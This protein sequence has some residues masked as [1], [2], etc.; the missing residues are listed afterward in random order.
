MQVGRLVAR[1]LTNPQIGTELGISLDG[2]KYHVSE[3]LGRLSLSTRREIAEQMEHI[4]EE[5]VMKARMV[6]ILL[7]VEDVSRSM[8]FYRDRL[9]FNVLHE[10][11]H[12]NRVT[13]ASFELFGVRLMVNEPGNVDST[14][15]RNR[16]AYEDAVL[17]FTVENVDL[18][19]GQLDNSDGI[20][21]EIWNHDYGMRDFYVRDP[22]GYELG[23]GTP[24]EEIKEA[25]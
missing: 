19:H 15:R 14:K 23:F 25:S 24:I 9:G 17:Y 21:G 16:P 5:S 8:A 4:E 1:G 13:G 18:L 10:W 22:D 20:I 7:N 2:A 3:L 6:T 12:G 11:K